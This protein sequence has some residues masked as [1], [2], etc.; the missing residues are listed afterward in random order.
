MRRRNAW[1]FILHHLYKTEHL[2]GAF[3]GVT[4]IFVGH[5]VVGL[6]MFA[7][8]LVNHKS[9]L[10]DVKMYLLK[11]K[12]SLLAAKEHKFGQIDLRFFEIFR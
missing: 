2:V 12:I 10:V 4:F 5:F 8:K 1:L 11:I 7:P 6:K 3:V 9:A